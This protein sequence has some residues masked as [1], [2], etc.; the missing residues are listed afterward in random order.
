MRTR[1]RLN[2]IINSNLDST[3]VLDDEGTN[4]GASIGVRSRIETRRVSNEK[5]RSSSDIPNAFRPSPPKRTKVNGQIDSNNAVS[6]SESDSTQKAIQCPICLESLD[7]LKKNSKRLKS[8]TCGHILCN[9]CLEATFKSSNLKS[10][11]FCPTCR[12]KLTRSKIH[13]LFL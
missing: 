7:E 5:A 4:P 6:T 13:D 12:T 8:T 1:H 2:R 10:S 9:E 11:I 3:I